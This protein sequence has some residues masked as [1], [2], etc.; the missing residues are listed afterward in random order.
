MY[1][2]VKIVLA[3]LLQQTRLA[4]VAPAPPKVRRQGF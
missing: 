3:T 4:L 2:E 1:E